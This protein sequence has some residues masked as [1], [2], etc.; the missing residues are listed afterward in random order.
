MIFAASKYFYIG[1]PKKNVPLS[2]KN[3]PKSLLSYC[4][5]YTQI[6]G[7]FLD[8]DNLFNLNGTKEHFLGQP[9]RGSVCQSVGLLVGRSID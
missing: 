7:S 4:P 9:V 5:V 6:K 1:C 8:K 3:V 2:H